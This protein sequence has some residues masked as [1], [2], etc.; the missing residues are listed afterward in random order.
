M[1]DALIAQ[2]TATGFEAL[3]SGLALIP[4]FKAHAQ[5]MGCGV[6]VDFGGQHL[7]S[8]CAGLA[9]VAKI[10]GEVYSYEANKTA[11]LGS[12]SR[13][14]YEWLSQSDRAKGE[15]N[16]IFKQLRGAQIREAIAQK[17]FENHQAQM[18]HAQEIV[19]FLQGK[20]APSGFQIKETT[21]GFYAWM[22]R[23]VKAL[24]AKS[25]QLAFEVAK[26]AERALQHNWGT[27]AGAVS[28][29]TT[30][31]GPRDCWQAKNSCSTSKPWK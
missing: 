7:H 18:Q 23:E 24:Y 16:Q 19:D 27:I 21:M 25:F 28:N 1:K 9:S 22:K 5:P 12:Y 30:W 4:Q 13:R 10:F 29:T 20:D 8:M 11:K 17:E 3:G 31:M 14:Q 15:I 6:S 2:G 26:K